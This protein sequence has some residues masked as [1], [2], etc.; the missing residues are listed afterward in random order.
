MLFS[1]TLVFVFEEDMD[2]IGPKQTISVQAIWIIAMHTV[3]EI[4]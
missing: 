4:G 2:F 1:I 3:P